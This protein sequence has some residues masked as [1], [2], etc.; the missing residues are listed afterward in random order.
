MVKMIIILS[1][2]GILIIG[3]SIYLTELI[4]QNQTEQIMRYKM[5]QVR[6]LADD[7]HVRIKTI[8]TIMNTTSNS[9]VFGTIKNAELVDEKLH[10]I[11]NDVEPEKREIATRLLAN[12]KDLDYVFFLLPDGKMYFLEPYVQQLNLTKNNFSYRDYYKGVMSTH[13][14]YISEVYVSDNNKHRV[15]SIATPVYSKTNGSFI[16]LWVGA[17]NLQSMDDSLNLIDLGNNGRLIYL[18]Q[19]GNVVA[20]SNKN[21]VSASQFE[22]LEGYMNARNGKEGTSVEMINNE[23]MLI[24]YT[25]LKI[26]GNT[27]VVLLVQPYGDAYY[28]EIATQDMLFVYVLVIVVILIISGFYVYRLTRQKTI[29]MEKLREADIKKEE[30]TAMVTHELKTPLVTINGY[31]EMLREP[32]FLG[33]LNAEQDDAISRIHESSIKLD[34]LIGDMLD[35]QKLDLQKMK[36]DKENFSGRIFMQEMVDM[37]SPMMQDKKIE[38]VNSTTDDLTVYGDK[39]RLTQVFGNLIRNSIDFVP[40]KCGRIEIGM[41]QDSDKAVFYVKD[42]GAGIPKDKQ[43]YLFKKFYQIDTSL[44]RKHGGTGLGLVI[45]KGIVDALGGKIWFESEE[46]KGTSFYFSIPTSNKL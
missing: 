27:W 19:H 32:G 24:A 40:E 39:S 6:I 13:N 44:K 3:S 42:N 5:N 26:L 35:T 11:P 10:G 36:F 8:A 29:L 43:P 16:G 41:Q 2:A 9:P 4:V 15:V 12:C 17:L 7:A 21:H 23:K 14:Q 20:D 37:F 30:F 45:C 22:N 28:T 25:P 31:S 33:T 38:F 18:D 1:S 46:G 34:R